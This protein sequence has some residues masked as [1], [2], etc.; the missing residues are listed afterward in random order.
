LPLF[1][2]VITDVKWEE[3]IKEWLENVVYLC[4]FSNHT[5]KYRI[6]QKDFNIITRIGDQYQSH[7]TID[8]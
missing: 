4:Y 7:T 3:L 5:L 6:L 1:E 8:T 2:V